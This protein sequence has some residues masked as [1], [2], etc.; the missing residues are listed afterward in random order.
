VRSGDPETSLLFDVFATGQA[1]RGLLE[2]AMRDAPLT[3]SDYA[4]YSAIFEMEAPTPSRLAERLG[5]P[6]TTAIDQVVRLEARGHARRVAN[7]RDRR[8]SLVVLTADGRSA[9]LAANAAF[10]R[11]HATLLA[12]L[13]DDEHAVRTA[14]ASLRAAIDEA[15]AGGTIATPPSGA[16]AG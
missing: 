5:M 14:L 8:G 16:P 3:P 7:P 11:A 13:G 1:V 12:A 2:A 10:E 6:L 4:I 9:H 15:I